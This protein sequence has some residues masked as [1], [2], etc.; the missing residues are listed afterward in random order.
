MIIF[1]DDLSRRRRSLGFV[2]VPSQASNDSWKFEYYVTEV[3]LVYVRLESHE[4]ISCAR[5]RESCPT[6]ILTNGSLKLI[7]VEIAIVEAPANL[8]IRRLLLSRSI[9]DKY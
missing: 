9:S 6:I 4:S 8:R 3:I 1:R 5:W 7:P 2:N